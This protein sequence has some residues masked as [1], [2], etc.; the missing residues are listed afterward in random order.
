[1]PDLG[2]AIRAKL[3]LA[4]GEE[5]FVYDAE[6]V[7][8]ALFAVLD[9]WE[10]PQDVLSRGH[11]AGEVAAANHT[12][13]VGRAKGID[14]ARDAIAAALGIAPLPWPPDGFTDLGHL[15]PGDTFEM[16]PGTSGVVWTE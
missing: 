10:D 11:S 15:A 4:P 14:E 6:M 8:A 9:L 2:E 16:P 13:N 12:F 5:S 3:A 1:M 7:Q